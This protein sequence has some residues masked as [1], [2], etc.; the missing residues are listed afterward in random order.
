MV[1]VI[2]RK[3]ELFILLSKIIR[4]KLKAG[5]I[6]L[7]A[8]INKN[9]FTRKRKLPL[10]L[11]ALQI[12]TMIRLPLQLS[13]DE[14][15]EALGKKEDTVSKQA[16][17]KARTNLNPEYIKE[18]FIETAKPMGKCKDIKLWNNKYRLCA[19]D[20][21]DIALDNASELKNHFGCSGR[22]KNATTALASVA[23]DPLNEWILDGSLNPYGTNE[24]DAAK[25]NI[26]AVCELPLRF[27]VKNLF[28]MDRGYPSKEFIAWLSDNKHKFLMRVRN[29]FSSDI[30]FAESNGIVSLTWESKTYSVRAIK[31]KLD[32]GEIETLITNLKKNELN[33]E[34]AGALYFKRW[35]IET[36]FNSLKNKLQLGNFS[37]RRVVTVMQD[38][39]ATLCMANYINSVRFQTDAVIAEASADKNN[40][41]NQTTNENRLINKCRKKLIR[42]LTANSDSER[43]KIFEELVSD[44]VSKPVELKPNRKNP[45]HSVPRKMKF[46][47]RYKSVI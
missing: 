17:S 36:K 8:S 31:V 28:I 3:I 2:M 38:F 4:E 5:N 11:L 40:M 12:L 35:D 16:V 43:T 20:G 23:H 18:F 10:E 14:V 46:H 9:N 29:K 27:R 25:A 7:C 37:G 42:A 1:V 44:I 33:S 30:D 34:D 22:T 45:P 15:Y 6:K 32:T 39:Y 24:R 13:T 41:H 26:S 19:I 21:S 47:D